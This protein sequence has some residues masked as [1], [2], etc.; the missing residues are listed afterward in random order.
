M[1]KDLSQFNLPELEEKVLAFW[2]TNQVFE[3]SLSLRRK[4]KVFR[5]FEGPPYAN[6]KPGIH[7]VEA[8][9]FKDIVLRYKTMRGY[10]VPRKAGWD[11]HGL[12]VEIAAEKQLG[13]KSKADIE[14]LGVA[15]FNQTAKEA[16]WAY[17]D[18]W[19]KMTERIGYWLDLKDAYVTYGN[20]YIETLWW[21]FKQI[22][23][24]K[25]L[26]K[27][28]KVVPWCTRCGTALAS[29]EL[30]QGY[31]EVTDTSVYVK[32][33]LLPGQKIGKSFTTDDA[34][35]VLSWTTTPWTLPGN[36][37]LAVGEK[38]EY[39]VVRKTPRLERFSDG[40]AIP[41][42]KPEYY[43]LAKNIINKQNPDLA[44][45]QKE[46]FW[47]EG[48]Y[49]VVQELTGN[50]LVGLAYEPLFN[51]PKL[52]SEV[53]YKIYAADFVTTTDGTGVVHT[54]VMYGED[55][56]AL[57]KKVGLPQY[58]TVDE[59][60]KFKHDVNNWDGTDLE[61]M[62]VKADETTERI[63]TQ[64]EKNNFFF[65]R[66]KYTHEY[67]HCWRCGT[68]LLYYARDSWFILMSKLRAELVKA[69]QTVDWV[70][71]HIKDGRFGEWLREVKD[72]NI[73]RERYWGTPLPI[74]EC[75]TCEHRELVGSLEEF[76][77]LAETS[78]N[79]YFAIRHGNSEVQLLGVAADDRN[80]FHL[81][82]QGIKEIEAAGKRLAKEKID[83][84]LTS[85][86]LRARESAAR[87]SKVFGGTSVVVDDRLAEIHIGQ[88]EHKPIAEYHAY[89]SSLLEKFTKRPSDGESL[90]DLKRRV[91]HV[92]RDC[93]TRYKDKKILF[94]SHDYP[95]WMLSGISGGLSNEAMVRAKEKRGDDFLRTGEFMKVVY[96]SL[97]RDPNGDVDL[98]R[99]FVD[100]ARLHCPKCK[101]AMRRVPEV[102]DVWFDSGAMPF[103][104]W[105]Y[106]FE[107]K[108]FVD[109][110][111]RF[112]ADYIAEALDQTRG[113]F[114]TLL[115]VSI[116]LKKGMPYH[117][118][119]CLGLI[120]DK[121][122]QKM[123]KSKGN[124]VEP[125]AVI[126]KYGVDPVRW[127]F[128]SSGDPSE[129][130]SF[131][132]AELVKIT[133]RFILILYNSFV[134]W[135]TYANQKS[136]ADPNVSTHPLDQWILSRLAS[137]ETLTRDNLDRYQIGAAARL[138]E[139]FSD[140]LSRWYI[141]R[142]RKR[143]QGSD[144]DMA[145]AVLCYALRTVSQLL[146]PFLP[147]FSE[148]LFQSLRD[149]RDPLS[150][151]LTDWPKTD[152]QKINKGL[153]SVM[154]DVRK[155]SSDGLALRA[156][157]QLKVRQ[158]LASLKIKNQKSVLKGNKELLEIL[159]D[160]VN[161]KE[162]IFD[163]KIKNEI[164]FDTVITPEL[165]QEGVLRELSRTI[166]QLRQ[167]AGLKVGDKIEVELRASPAILGVVAIKEKDLREAVGAVRVIL[168]TTDV[169][170][171]AKF[172]IKLDSKLG[173]EPLWV[174]IRKV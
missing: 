80:A 152:K 111:I 14:K 165:Y 104:Q 49:E 137:L 91:A 93:E 108:D 161:V 101:K 68:P 136:K 87:L 122:G 74:W 150:V 2:K 125:W 63:I 159:K 66:E 10:Y 160:E 1:L 30:A 48:R 69:N 38:I 22:W 156:E 54:A 65:K 24:R 81:T 106:P 57:G 97:P 149:A 141:R 157:A 70:P 117:N 56:Y 78:G 146:A 166:Q 29:H 46:I 110:K 102:A 118:V 95:L 45:N 50:K 168:Q 36:V 155:L 84:I 9:V 34:T 32:F 59:E 119:V 109:K 18:E 134:F 77:A 5:F 105:H 173:D 92:L 67:P 4:Q 98:H 43:V 55:D 131:D 6:G 147:F 16:V 88:F 26:V 163:S 128:F 115:A 132:E 139:E 61:G 99:P 151:H 113:W 112:P 169:K 11:T 142:S 71:E 116:L 172:D 167:E 53:S 40:G 3:K 89:F 127:F 15:L 58:H 174:A 64:L 145:S 51:V 133:R 8:R 35:Y 135:S 103:A 154:A 62:L 60:G 164:E 21:I 79:R 19:E 27:G 148:A 13:L 25:L 33:K 44:L 138:I 153:L 130:R 82:G 17:K 37:A 31:K 42:Y 39:V 72:W 144:R 75:E 162:I 28:H 96:H 90:N 140:D 73:S 7:H 85:P 107:H 20:D 52:K 120:L 83:L 124:I 23:K 143:F 114:Y 171:S 41:N 76:S 170:K 94:V 12:P 121:H 47:F 86:V 123:S 158:P 126:Q 100:T 129:P